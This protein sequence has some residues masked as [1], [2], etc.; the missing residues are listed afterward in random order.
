M[1]GLIKH[2]DGGLHLFFDPVDDFMINSMFAVLMFR[3]GVEVGL[4]DIEPLPLAGDSVVKVLTAFD[5][6]GLILLLLGL[7]F[8]D[9]LL[10]FLLRDVLILV[11]FRLFG[12]GAGH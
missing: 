7:H 12:V 8:L 2:L 3:D 5:L 9:Q 1:L 4:G 10:V 11:Q 6:V